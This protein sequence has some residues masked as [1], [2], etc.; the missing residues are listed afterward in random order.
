LFSPFEQADSST[1]RKY[2]GTGLGLTISRRLAE[3]MGGTIQVSSMPGRGSRFEL[4]LPCVE[5]VQ[6]VET[7]PA[8]WATGVGGTRLDGIRILAA[9]DNDV[10][11]LVLQDMLTGAGAQVTLVNN[12]RLAVAA[13]ERAA[14]SFDLVL[15]DVQMPEMDGFEAT[16]QILRI[17]PDLPVIGQTAHA[18]AEDHEKCRAAGMVQTMTKPIDIDT[19]V[20]VVLHHARRTPGVLPAAMGLPRI[21]GAGETALA[22]VARAPTFRGRA[23]DWTQLESNFGQRPGFV[24]KLVGLALNSLA[25]N[26][27]GLRAAAAAADM[28]TLAFIAHTV[29]GTSGNLFANELR[30]QAQATEFAARAA[31]PEAIGLA[32]QLAATLEMVL[33]EIRRYL[34][35]DCR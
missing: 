17:A 32:E 12:G 29:K 26:P 19:L 31:N 30:T 15:M 2:G 18:L 9:E 8:V 33:E 16:R 10:N 1:T 4:R 25:E 24:A 35:S 27:A 11:R 23:I 14:D 7:L 21:V 13:V 20:S 34:A 28:E 3:L 5:S 6:Y 22:T